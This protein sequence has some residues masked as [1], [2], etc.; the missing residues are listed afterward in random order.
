MNAR[1]QRTR[2]VPEVLQSSLAD[3]GPAALGAVLQGFG[4][5]ADYDAL[6]E[7][8]QTDVD[9]TS[10]DALG[11]LGRELGLDCQQIL[12]PHDHF[13]LPEA[14]CLPAIV[15]TRSAGGLLHFVVVWRKLGPYVEVLDPG[16]GRHWLG[17]RRLLAQMPTLPLRVSGAAFRR[18]AGSMDAERPFRARL[19]ALGIT[20]SRAS[21]LLAVPARDP[22]WL[23]F[24]R[25]DAALRMATTLAGARALRRG[26]E[27]EQ[28]L[29]RLIQDDGGPIP[30][31]FRWVR[32]MPE[33]RAALLAHGSVILRFSG[34]SR[35]VSN[36]NS[37]ATALR[38]S[39]AASR[40]SAPSAFPKDAAEQLAGPEL[41]PLRV[42]WS[43]LRASAG[44]DLLPWVGAIALSAL[45]VPVETF[46]L[47]A[48]LD[49]ERHLALGYQQLAA[50]GGALVLL[51]AALMLDFWCGTMTARLGREIETRVRA[52]LL[53]RLP[54]LPDRYL[55]TRSSS[56][57]ASRGHSM[58]MLRTLPIIWAQMARSAAVV[59][60]LTAALVWIYPDGF[61]GIAALA[62]S[63][64]LLPFAG[65]RVLAEKSLR[66]HTLAAAL[67]RF[68][69][70][71][72]LGAVPVRVHGAERAIRAAHEHLLT[73]W[74]RTAQ[75][76]HR[77]NAIVLAAQL[78]VTTA[79]ALA[80]VLEYFHEAQAGTGL[81]LLAFLAL[82][83]PLSANEL[84]TA[85][86]SARSSKTVALRVLAPLAAHVETL[87]DAEPATPSSEPQP[88]EDTKIAAWRG[89]SISLHGVSVVA[90][91]QRLLSDVTL[92]VSAGEHLGII[93]V[94]GAGKSSLLGLLLGWHRTAEGTLTV[95]GRAVNGA[96]IGALRQQT[97][98]VDPSVQLWD[99]TLL[100]NLAYGSEGDAR[101]PLADA[102]STAD[103]LEVLESL[104]EGLQSSLGE[105]GVRL[106]GGQGQRVRL[107]RALMR[108]APRLVLLDEP[109]RGLERSRRVDL[110]GRVRRHWRAATLL[111][112][113]H[114]V[115][116]TL[117]LDRVCVI[118]GGRLVEHGHP[119][120]LAADPSSRYAQMLR[121]A[122]E[123]R[124]RCWE[125][126]AWRRLAVHGGRISEASPRENA[127]VS[128]RTLESLEASSP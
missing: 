114:D 8:C 119:R 18:W 124:R 72:L 106:S 10:I 49:M 22:S 104:P 102:L 69:L 99:R 40:R 73:D 108:H 51:A 76:L 19:S 123:L 111:F 98:W 92:E 35:G 115:E 57:M 3:C 79:I 128:E 60:A 36:G 93:G 58:H 78:T 70:D 113:S 110:L 50:V 24:A 74:A 86:F 101:A 42:L 6:R 97:A 121:R 2:R 67:D 43:L 127:R 84:V 21:L 11:A 28:L 112:V 7:R 91:G 56:D 103:L 59:L 85:G 52:A 66:L 31:R 25:F 4:I 62:S 16:S 23:A 116:D 44:A 89:V 54:Q 38:G 94:S 15:V 41:E 47:R 37:R 13:L 95:D 80:V 65:R 9:G 77:G 53:E 87:D 48:L 64:L 20:R 29:A 107:G 63:A 81:L 1:S 12:V 109:F 17:A 117:G 96:E 75:A 30:E 71:T 125:S 5:H 82:R 33:D 90:G 68:Y 126:D 88:A 34:F 55:R 105:G 45:L 39:T 14:R 118:D 83:L 122:N 27:A 61:L 32:P 26:R 46:L 100:E 120:Q